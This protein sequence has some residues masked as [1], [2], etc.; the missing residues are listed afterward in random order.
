[1]TVAGWLRA[2]RLAPEIR[3]REGVLAGADA[4]FRSRFQL[5][6]LNAEWQ[7]TVERVP[8]FR[9]LRRERGIPETFESLEGFCERVPPMTRETLQRELPRLSVEQSRA[10]LVRITGGST[11]QPVQLP[12]WR[13]EFAATAPDLWVGR[14]WYGIGP[15]SRLFLLWGHSHLLGSGWRG[16]LNAAR[17]TLND[18]LL[19]Y[20]RVSAYDLRPEAM[21]RAGDAL[22]RCRVRYMLGYSVALDLMARANRDR[23]REFARLRLAAVIGTAEAFPSA[24]SAALVGDVFG[25]PVAME[26]GAVETGLV[27]HTHP[28][29]GYR[30]FW[31]S[32]LVEAE[33]GNDTRHVVRVTSLYPRCLP[34]VRYELGDEIELD[35]AAPAH[36]V[37]LDRFE[38]VIG[39]CNDY[40]PLAD[41]T[42]IHSEAF[43]HAM[44]PCPEVRAFQVLYESARIRVRFVSDAPLSEAGGAGIRAR[45]RR[46]HPSLGAVE[47]LRVD[48]LRRRSRARPAWSWRSSGRGP[49]E[50]GARGAR[51]DRSGSAFVVARRDRPR[52]RWGNRQRDSR[53][54]AR[55]RRGDRSRPRRARRPRAASR[56]GAQAAARR[57][58]QRLARGVQARFAWQLWR[59]QRRHR[60]D[61][62]FVDHLGLARTFRLPV[63]GF[64][65]RYA[66]FVHGGELVAAA[67]GSRRWAL[68][69]ASLL[70]TNSRYT[71][72]LVGACCPRSRRRSASSGLASILRNSASGALPAHGTPRELAA[73]IVGRLWSA[74]RGKGHDALL[75][76]WPEV[77][78]RCPG[79]ELW[80][81]GEGDDAPRLRAKA[82][83]LGIAR[84][85]RFLGR[86]SDADLG[87]LYRR[88]SVYAMPSR[89]EDRTRVRR[90]DVA[91][92]PLHRVDA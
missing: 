50:A 33:R 27:A 65:P 21:R 92:H 30:V 28:D 16:R 72:G 11:S 35:A 7:R 53:H 57:G 51:P 74:E 31:G 18:R 38:R 47:L 22:L 88:A 64:P 25:A 46:I 36:V 12:A 70:L 48:R 9:A 68:R 1:M 32:Y 69:H 75:E 2:R 15:E 14:G 80:I 13:S 10:E 17:R 5:E 24:D 79:A 23:A 86:V 76:A 89:Q 8:Y 45:L 49:G 44:R 55:D 42:R 29:G 61:L 73:L 6:R 43:S 66:I 3:R 59:A 90:G 34:L 71:A 37:G 85:V 77:E 83:A 60:H 81:A 87:T 56:C 39:R 62:V 40:V 78:R 41:G 20:Q 19:G 82:T 84:R 26:Y 4:A 58:E 67:A 91:R 54:R 52:H 63:P